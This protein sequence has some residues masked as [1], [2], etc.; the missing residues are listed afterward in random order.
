MPAHRSLRTRLLY[1]TGLASLLLV[2][3]SSGPVHAQDAT[4]QVNPATGNFNTATNWTPN[5]VPSGTAT[6][7]FHQHAEC[8]LLRLHNR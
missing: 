6:F 4:W 2:A 7:G 5:S 8:E 3:A 1:S